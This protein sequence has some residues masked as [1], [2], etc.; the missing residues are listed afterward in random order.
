MAPLKARPK[1]ELAKADHALAQEHPRHVATA[2]LVCH[3]EEGYREAKAESRAQPG[4]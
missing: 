3:Q 2:T 4:R 1:A